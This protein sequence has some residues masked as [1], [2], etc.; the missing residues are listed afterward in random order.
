MVYDLYWESHYD[1]R[2]I[3]YD[4]SSYYGCTYDR[5]SDVY[6]CCPIPREEAIEEIVEYA[7]TDGVRIETPIY[8]ESLVEVLKAT[9]ETLKRRK[10]RRGREYYPTLIV[11]VHSPE[12]LDEVR[13]LEDV[14]E[15]SGI[16]LTKDTFEAIELK[17]E[18]EWY[19]Y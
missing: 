19:G 8:L 2:S 9:A 16:M 14:L 11:L 12:K 17:E 7:I 6:K 3:L 5:L 1:K 15:L 13:T 18:K 10:A 4:G